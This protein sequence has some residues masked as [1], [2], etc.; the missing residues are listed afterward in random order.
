MFIGNESILPNEICI[1]A[2][3]NDKVDEIKQML[4]AANI[5]YLDLSSSKQNVNAVNVS[6]FHNM[7][8]HEFKIVFV[9]GMSEDRVPLKHSNYNNLSDKE[10]KS[11]HQQERSLYYVVFS[12]AIQQI[13]I[14]GVGEKSGWI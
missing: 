4:N 2:R 1:S 6:T 7:K 10:L 8:G 13:Y 12:R 11:Y 14:T 5:K 9:K 3:T